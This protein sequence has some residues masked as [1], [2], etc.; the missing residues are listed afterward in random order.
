MR[1]TGS[2]EVLVADLGL[3]ARPRPKAIRT[4]VLRCVW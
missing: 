2:V 4:R 1:A 3:V